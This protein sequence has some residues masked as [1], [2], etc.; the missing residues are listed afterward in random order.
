MTN[1]A[2]I[3]YSSTGTITAIAR[4][5]AAAAEAAGASVRLRRVAELAPQAVIDSVPGWAEN[6]AATSD[7][8]EATPDD[9]VWADAVIF[10]TPTR[11]GNVASQVKQFIDTLGGL[12]YQGLLAD[13]VY[14]GFTST[15]TAHGGHESTL[16][17]LGN[18]FH[19]FGGI[20]VPPGY[21]DPVHANPYGVSH[22]TANGTIPV[23][24]ETLAAARAQAVRVVRFASALSQV[25]QAA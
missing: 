4:E 24:E 3:Y 13:K 21:T 5:M 14:S 8:P 15:A 12:Q 23:G 22:H 19:H 1:L 2:V 18:T 16:L 6:V 11:F 9:M 10:G 20:I 17:A 7:I 25:G